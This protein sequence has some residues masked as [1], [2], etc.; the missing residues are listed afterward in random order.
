MASKLSISSGFIILF[1]ILLLS[2]SISITSGSPMLMKEGLNETNAKKVIEILI[3]EKSPMD[4]IIKIKEFAKTD[5]GLQNKISN[6]ENQISVDVSKLKTNLGND[7]NKNIK[8]IKSKIENNTKPASLLLKDIKVYLINNK[9][10]EYI[11]FVENI[12]KRIDVQLNKLKGEIEKDNNIK[13]ILS[14]P[15]SQSFNTSSKQ[16]VSKDRNIIASPSNY[17]PVSTSSTIRRNIKYR[18]NE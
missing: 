6:I 1:C 15:A 13:P 9:A 4:K 10:N 5:K 7:K 17:Q 12:E 18:E 14:A 2:I 16:S 3:T 8:S 11:E